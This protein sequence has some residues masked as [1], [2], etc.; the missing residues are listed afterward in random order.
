MRILIAQRN[1]SVGL[2]LA[3]ALRERLFLSDVCARGKTAL[4]L[5]VG[6]QYEAAILDREL[7]RRSILNTIRIHVPIIMT[8][9]DRSARTIV[10]ALREGADNYITEV[11]RPEDAGAVLHAI[12]RRHH[13]YADSVVELGEV[14]LDLERNYV[15][16]RRGE[17]QLA[18]EEYFALRILMLNQGYPVTYEKLKD[19]MYEDPDAVPDRSVV[20]A[21]ARVRRMLRDRTGLEYVSK[22]LGSRTYTFLAPDTR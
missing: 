21:V 6:R 20:R 9:P 10:S 7:P 5:L 2:A 19:S 14:A 3:K 4:R 11:I 17:G 18:E 16:I 8:S 22:Q 15:R 13:N 1:R 12:I